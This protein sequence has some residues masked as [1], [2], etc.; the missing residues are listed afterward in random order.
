MFDVVWHVCVMIAQVLSRTFVGD[1]IKE[2]HRDLQKAVN[3]DHP[4]G[5]R[6][7]GPENSAFEIEKKDIEA[8]LDALDKVVGANLPN[9][10]P[11]FDAPAGVEEKSARPQGLLF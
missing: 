2:I 9:G 7:R 1:R 3:E 4:Q 8:A 6:R 11:S 5:A 10:Q